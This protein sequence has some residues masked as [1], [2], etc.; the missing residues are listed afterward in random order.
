MCR[1]PRTVRPRVEGLE[2][3]L[4]LSTLLPGYSE[5][6]VA[7]GLVGPTAMEIAPDGR[8]LVAEQRGTL[9]VIR[10]GQLLDTPFL[11]LNV[12]PRGERGLIGVTMDPNFESNGY[13]YVYYTV[14]GSSSHNRVSR[15]TADGDLAAPGSEVPILDL[16]PL[17]GATNHNG[18]ALHFAPD[19]TLFVAVGENAR[20]DLAQ[21]LDSRLGKLLRINSDGSIPADNPFFNTLNGPNRAIWALGL[22]NPYTFAIDT[23]SGPD[24]PRVFIN[25]VGQSTWEEVDRGIAGANYGWPRT[26]GPTNAPEIVGP[27]VSYRH[28][29]DPTACAISGG[30]FGTLADVGSPDG[31]RAAYFY[32]DFCAS[33]IRSYGLDRGDTL[34]F[35]SGLPFG[36][37]DLDVAK[38]SGDL[39]YLARGGG[40][41]SGVV[42][43]IFADA[44]PTFSG[45][46]ADTPAVVG[47]TATIYGPGITSP[48]PV[49]FQ[50]QRN[51]MDIPGAV[52]PTLVIANVRP[53]DIGA[54]YRL[55][56]TNRAGSTISGAG[57]LVLNNP[58]G[59]GL[60]RDLLGRPADPG[61]LEVSTRFLADGG[62]RSALV[63]AFLTSREGQAHSVDLLYR[64][65]LN[66]PLAVTEADYWVS[67]LGS[68]ASLSDV[69][70]AIFNSP[71]YIGRAAGSSE[72]LARQLF[73][74]LYGRAP[75]PP[76][77]VAAVD[78]IDKGLYGAMTRHLAVS[79]E[80]IGHEVAG[81]YGRYLRRPADPSELVGWVELR[82]EGIPRV[83]ALG[84]FLAT[85]EYR[86]VTSRLFT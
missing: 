52:D 13:I 33:F 48:S 27:L 55:I 17:T 25:D 79:A 67:V 42:G 80:A 38:G 14:P 32:A 15:F 51:G 50:W 43:R 12:D 8:I 31:T 56:A 57:T 22:R 85:A 26:E 10:D 81:W 6:T 60:S 53:E 62:D 63:S 34:P 46:V 1:R 30:D 44:T 74:D 39:L 9:R 45:P 35:A 82:S 47:A 77:S 16:D 69:R 28:E 61:L 3:R 73:S 66:R 11:N 19:G 20:P 54:R 83:Q 70:V 40:A 86:A 2:P 5:S 24:A 75:A 21:S 71:E 37:V 23:T 7:T 18:G 36:V 64:D 58:Y 4:A 59:E 68:G 76:E 65:L 49:S 78:A 72:T 84:R 41:A 29:G